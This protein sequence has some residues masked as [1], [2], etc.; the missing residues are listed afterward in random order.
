MKSEKIYFL[1][2]IKKYINNFLDYVF[3]QFCL[4][5]QREGTI[6]CATCLKKLELLP[7][8]PKPWPEENFFFD[9]CHVCLDYHNPLIKK[10][11]KKYKYGFF[12]NLAEPI[13]DLYI[14][15]IKKLKLSN[16]YIL[17]NT[18]LHPSKKRKRGFDQTEI[19]AKKISSKTN[20][21]YYDLLVRAKRTKTQAQL[22][23]LARQKNVNQ[24]F[25]I[26][27]NID[28]NLIKGQKIVLIDDI[29]TTGA[30]LNEAAL[31]LKKAGFSQIIGLA[32]A[33]N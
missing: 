33:K 23:K 19:L 8:N 10:L 15:K 2:K 30:T 4:G 27:K 21:N 18:P 6:F 26:N 1:P 11:I 13:A 14:Q 32:L 3:P 22:D 28:L 20:L 31:V 24:A 9:E 16:D 25:I 7:N 17:C 12:D 29:A 5:C